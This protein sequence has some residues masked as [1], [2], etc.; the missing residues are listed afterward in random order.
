[1]RAI[2]IEEF[3]RIDI[4]CKTVVI[5]GAGHVAKA[6]ASVLRTLG[7]KITIID[8]RSEVADSARS[9]DAKVICCDFAKALN[10]I[11]SDND[12]YYIVATYGHSYDYECLCSILQKSYAYVGLLSSH[13]KADIMRN[14]LTIDG[15]DA[16]KVAS[17]HS[18]IG[19]SIKA[20]TPEEIAVSIAAQI[21]LC[22]N[23]SALISYGKPII[24]N[25]MKSFVNSSKGPFVM[26]T[27]IK[28]EGS[29]PRDVGTT[30]IFRNDNTF[31]GTI[32]GGSVEEG[33]KQVA[34]GIFKAYERESFNKESYDRKLCDRK[35]CDN[36]SFDRITVD[37]KPYIQQFDTATLRCDSPI[38][39]IKCG[40]TVTVEF[41]LIS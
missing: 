5:C 18:P 2:T 25:E 31:C 22:K 9:L 16:D 32:G 29:A 1:M 19:L 11:P 26:A 35:P 6:T 33:C 3:N 8:N 34:A 10:E 37:I 40:G 38:S 28:K 27:I 13:S 39:N 20:H 17:L 15:F 23:S 30:M 4:D 41:F 24:T 7:F 21:I 12:T 14:R 36:E